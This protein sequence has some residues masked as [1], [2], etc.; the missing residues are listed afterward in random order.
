MTGDLRLSVLGS[1]LSVPATDDDLERWRGQWSRCLAA[2]GSAADD[3]VRP[4]NQDDPDRRDYSLASALTLAGIRQAAG[5]R[6][7]LHA[8]GVAD[9][10]TGDVAVL[11]AA[12]GTGK[13]TAAHRLCSAGFGYVTDETVSIGDRL[14]ILPYPKP[15]SVV[16]A[17]DDPGHKSQHG[18]D[19]LDLPICPPDPHATRFVLLDRADDAATVTLEPVPLLDGLLDLIP[20]TSALPAMRDPLWTLARAACDT[21]GVWRLRYR[22]IEQAAQLLRDAL[23]QR[24]TEP[25]ELVHLAPPDADALPDRY[26]R[27][28]PPV[29]ED[30]RR[31]GSQ[32]EPQTLVRRASYTDAVGI[33]GEVLLL[34]GSSP[35]RLS[36][37]GATIWS[38]SAKEASLEELTQVCVNQHGDHPDSTELVSAA[39]QAMR[40]HGILE[41][42]VPQVSHPAAG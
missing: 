36:G 19:E 38:H 34:V 42:V 35:A 41:T 39:V 24:P 40:D 31:D 30:R 3:E 16:I 27:L 12:S 5:S 6:L 9:R 14:D 1:V 15:L 29:S 25:A 37:L 2:P 28:P 21:G 23:R 13:T 18:P 11:V 26:F 20:H 7:M 22:D 10:V 33:D 32:P 17:T 4:G 8:C